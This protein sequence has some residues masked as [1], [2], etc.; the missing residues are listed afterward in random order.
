MSGSLCCQV[1]IEHCKSAIIEIKNDLKKYQLSIPQSM[2]FA[3]DS[4]LWIKAEANWLCLTCQDLLAMWHPTR[5]IT[6]CIWIYFYINNSFYL[7][8]FFFTPIYVTQILSG[9]ELNPHH[10]CATPGSYINTSATRSI[11]S[12]DPLLMPYLSIPLSTL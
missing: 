1:V 9:Q 4:C 7:S 11:V 10:C 12:G 3:P 6:Y 8:I 5:R 2:C